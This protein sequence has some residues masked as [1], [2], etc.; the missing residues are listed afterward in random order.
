M[1]DFVGY[2]QRR[3]AFFLPRFGPP[4]GNTV[5]PACLGLISMGCYKWRDRYC[6]KS[7]GNRELWRGSLL[8]CLSWP[9]IDGQVSRSTPSRSTKQRF[10]YTNLPWALRFLPPLPMSNHDCLRY[11]HCSWA[12]W[13]SYRIL[14]DVL[15]L[16]RTMGS[17]GRYSKGHAHVS[18][19]QVLGGVEDSSKDLRSSYMSNSPVTCRKP[20]YHREF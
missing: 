18:S 11:R 6:S 2:K 12:S 7:K 14:F 10:P 3:E 16:G 4:E 17:K 20:A 15:L 13:A 5:R 1:G 9:Y 19:P 8:G